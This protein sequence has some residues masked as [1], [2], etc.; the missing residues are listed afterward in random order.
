[1]AKVHVVYHV[2]EDIKLSTRFQKNLQKLDKVLLN[3]Q[4]FPTK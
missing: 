3:S 2:T 1:M 4:N